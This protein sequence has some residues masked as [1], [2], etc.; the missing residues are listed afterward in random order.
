MR[1]VDSSKRQRLLEQR[2][3]HRARHGS[4]LRAADEDRITVR[5]LLVAFDFETDE[6]AQRI[7]AAILDRRLADVV[8]FFLCRHSEADAGLE[9]VGR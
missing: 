4:D 8:L 7:G 1:D 3:P 9:R 2:R 6:L 5:R